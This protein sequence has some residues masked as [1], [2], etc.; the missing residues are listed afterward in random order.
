MSEGKKRYFQGNIKNTFKPNISYII[1]FYVTPLFCCDMYNVCDA[2]KCTSLLNRP[3]EYQPTEFWNMCTTMPYQQLGG[4]MVLQDKNCENTGLLI[5]WVS[6]ST[7]IMHQFWKSYSIEVHGKI[8]TSGK[9]VNNFFKV[10]SCHTPWKTIDPQN[11]QHFRQP[12]SDSNHHSPDT[13]VT[14]PNLPGINFNEIKLR[15]LYGQ[16]MRNHECK[17]NSRVPFKSITEKSFCA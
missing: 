9:Q 12:G 5:K 3:T 10:L 1:F 11:W 7:A 15:L 8:V 16:D 13:R 14:V 6:D 2:M 4:K 17:A